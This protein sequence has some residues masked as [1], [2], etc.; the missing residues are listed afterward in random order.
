M[1]MY[2]ERGT[3]NLN[4]TTGNRQLAIEHVPI[5]NFTH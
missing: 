2:Y 3:H 4:F 1:H 5:H